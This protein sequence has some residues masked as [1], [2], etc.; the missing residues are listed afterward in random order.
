[1]KKLVFLA[2]A[3]VALA[4]LAPVANA[5]VLSD[6]PLLSA[7][8]LA[9]GMGGNFEFANNAFGGSE[10]VNDRKQEFN[11]GVYVA[12]NLVPDCS[13]VAS[14]TLGLSSRQVR[15]QVGVRVTLFRGDK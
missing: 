9:L 1:M 11:A 12:Y 15:T 4:S 3:L 2:L 6:V 5:Q 8:R 14:S 13:L 7:K 10:P